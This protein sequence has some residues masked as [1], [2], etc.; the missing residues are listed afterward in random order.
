[1]RID[2]KKIKATTVKVTLE[3]GQAAMPHRHPGPMFGYVLEGEYEWT[4][5]DQVAK[6]LK[7]GDTFYEPT[8]CLHWVSKNAG[9]SEARASAC[10]VAGPAG[11]QG[12]VH[13]R[14]AREE[15]VM[16]SDLLR[17][18]VTSPTRSPSRSGG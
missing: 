5:D 6:T 3:P 8:S 11:Y 7:V 18:R 16:E 15:G 4:F 14:E 13:P 12:A 1:M 10:R 17:R 2:G 9:K